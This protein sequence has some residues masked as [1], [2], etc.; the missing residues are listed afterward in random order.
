[1]FRL[2]EKEVAFH[3][4][5]P[6][7]A[8]FNHR[9]NLNDLHKQPMNCNNMSQQRINNVIEYIE[10]LNNLN[11][12]SKTMIYRG[13]ADSDWEI[14]SSAYRELSKNG[15]P[16][17]PTILKEYHHRLLEGVRRLHDIT[18]SNENDVTILSQLQH[19]KA[20]TVLIDYTYNPLAALWFACTDKSC[21]NK[22]GCVYAVEESFTQNIFPL[23]NDDLDF[24]FKSTEITYVYHPYQI[25]QRIINQ[26]SVFL[27]RW[28]GKID[29][30]QQIQILIPQK[31]KEGIIQELQ[32]LGVT[33]KTLFQD[34]IGFIDTFDFDTD[35]KSRCASLV[36]KARE[37]L[38]GDKPNYS[39]AKF[40][41]NQ[42][43]ELARS[44]KGKED[45]AYIYHELG[46]ISYRNNCFKDALSY[47]DKAINEKKKY[48]KDNDISI[49][50]TEVAK[51]LTYIKKGDYSEALPLF[52]KAKDKYMLSA[53]NNPSNANVLSNIA[54]I[55]REMGEYNKAKE[56]ATKAEIIAREYLG[57]D[58]K[59]YAYI[60]NCV[61]SVCA[62]IG[63]EKEAKDMFETALRIFRRSYISE[64]NLDMVYTYLKIASLYSLNKKFDGVSKMPNSLKTAY[65][66][67]KK[68]PEESLAVKR[69]YAHA[70]TIQA[71]YCYLSGKFE[72][73]KEW[74]E[75]AIQYSHDFG[76]N[77]PKMIDTNIFYGEILFSTRE[78]KNALNC[79]EKAYNKLLTINEKHPDVINC[80]NYIDKCKKEL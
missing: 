22:D 16:V 46:Y 52:E 21:M 13:Q 49:I 17:P 54:N 36:V 80:R 26:Q 7:F 25:N 59:N 55:Y 10:V 1:M 2:K 60:I 19:N 48:L 64:N 5:L 61:G 8:L 4:F 78:Y 44:Y 47:Y 66:L 69:A 65:D 71:K 33:R 74:C 24:L 6:N 79:F 20:K 51:G 41:L 72:K 58:S 57:N 27:I 31:K 50:Y 12:S 34:F 37:T 75:K 14:T 3:V 23:K 15:S 42:A 45:M 9:F 38:E 62:K 67:L 11:C 32:V 30:S 40:Y 53:E 77:H 35:N 70:Y 28:L 39:D 18:I 68:M 73:A 43:Y 63:K 56:M 76:E 29:K